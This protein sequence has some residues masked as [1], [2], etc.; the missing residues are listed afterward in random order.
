MQYLYI[1]FP[2]MLVPLVMGFA[3]LLSSKSAFENAGPS[4]WWFVRQSSI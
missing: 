4:F 2:K 3:L 1:S